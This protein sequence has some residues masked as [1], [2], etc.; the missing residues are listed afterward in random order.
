MRSR[1]LSRRET[2]HH[3]DVS[4][5][6]LPRISDMTRFTLRED[7][8]S[9]GGVA[10]GPTPSPQPRCFT[11]LP[12][13]LDAVVVCFLWQRETPVDPMMLEREVCFSVLPPRATG[14]SLH[15][16]PPP[17]AAVVQAS[18]PTAKDEPT[19]SESIVPASPASSEERLDRFV[20]AIQKRSDPPLLAAPPVRRCSRHLPWPQVQQLKT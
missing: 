20:D 7:V 2:C 6:V 10:T 1:K 12:P 3:H 15:T 16:S 4:S 17:A 8:T 14:S 11:P 5:E 9:R 18:V 13:Q 19:N